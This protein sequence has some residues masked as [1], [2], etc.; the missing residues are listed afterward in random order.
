MTCDECGAAFDTS[1]LQELSRK[2]AWWYWLVLPMLVLPALI[3]LVA[4]QIDR[5]LPGRR[6]DAG[7]TFWALAASP[8]YLY[9]MCAWIFASHRLARW[10]F[11]AIPAA[12]VLTVLNLLLAAAAFILRS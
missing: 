5:L 10:C 4:P 12:I 6:L 11:G 1:R 8:L 9:V 7:L 2:P 3:V